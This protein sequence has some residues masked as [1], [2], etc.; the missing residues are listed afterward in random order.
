YRFAAIP[1]SYVTAVA[2]ADR[3]SVLSPTNTGLAVPSML[4]VYGL[5]QHLA[6]VRSIELPVV[7]L[8][9]N[10]QVLKELMLEQGKRAVEEDGAQVIVPGCGEIYGI[11]G[12]LTAAL[13]VPVLDPRAVV[14]GFTEMLIGM[15]LTHSKRAYPRP[16]EKRREL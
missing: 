8:R 3:F 14:M 5:E 2:L 15:T 13:G 7:D 12:D 9:S 10:L 16:P 6:S 11:A 4:R 1:S